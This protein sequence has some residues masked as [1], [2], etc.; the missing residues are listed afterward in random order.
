MTA[1]RSS[2][3]CALLLRFGRFPAVRAIRSELRYRGFVNTRPLL[4]GGK[5]E[6]MAIIQRSKR[7][8]FNVFREVK[9][10][11]SVYSDLPG[12]GDCF[13]AVS[14]GGFSS[15][16]FIVFVAQKTK[17]NRMYASTLRIGRKH[18]YILDH[19]HKKGNLDWCGFCRRLDHGVRSTERGQ[20]I[21][22]LR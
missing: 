4:R 6:I 18:L 5:G 11:S 10:L 15:I 22:V 3:N 17:I 19:L 20:K 16:A 8:R 21:Q 9:E 14:C 1:F 12:D 7:K 2:T 13:K